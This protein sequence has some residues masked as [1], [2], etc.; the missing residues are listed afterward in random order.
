MKKYIYYFLY[1]TVGQ[2][3]PGSSFKIGK[4]RLGCGY[5]RGRLAKG[6][7]AKC[8]HDVNINK[9][10]V[11]NSHIT[12]GN[13]SGI[14]ANAT[15]QG[16]LHIGNNVMM[17]A[18]C[19]VYTK[20]HCFDRIDI[21]MMEQGYKN[22]QPVFIDD[23]VWIGGR[24]IILPGRHIGKGA[25]IGAGSVIT[26]DVPEFAIVGGNPAKVLRFRNK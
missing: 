18:D 21:P 19:I 13:N 12:I 9:H 22:T 20:N 11:L 10:A 23:D 15:I 24:V 8:G 25:I 17:G 2:L 1:Q 7:L 14:G 3:L 16:E 5:I 4:I 6:F 26:K